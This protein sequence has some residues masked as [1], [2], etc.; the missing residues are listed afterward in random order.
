MPAGHRVLK[1]SEE[2]IWKWNK[3]LFR[4]GRSLSSSLIFNNDEKWASAHIEGFMKR[5]HFWLSGQIWVTFEA[6][7]IMDSELKS[8]FG[9][10]IS[11]FSTWTIANN[12]KS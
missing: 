10:T 9:Q 4:T 8:V 1:V 11:G 12:E 3:S 6:T 2:S 7:G 5:Y